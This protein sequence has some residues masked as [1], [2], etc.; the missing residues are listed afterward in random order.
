MRTKGSSRFA[1]YFKVQFR[2]ALDAWQDIQKAFSTEEEARAAF[3]PFKQCR[4]MRITEDGR[5]PIP[6]Q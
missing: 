3:L 2:N 5:E 4:I 6:Q 1:P